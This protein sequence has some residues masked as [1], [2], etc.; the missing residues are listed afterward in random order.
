MQRALCL[1]RAGHDG[2]QCH[3]LLCSAGC[4]VPVR[5]A[6]EQLCVCM[7]VCVHVCVRV[8]VRVRV[9]GFMHSHWVEVG[10]RTHTHIQHTYTHTYNIHTRT[11]TRMHTQVQ[12]PATRI[13]HLC[14]KACLA[15]L[16]PLSHISAHTHTHTH[17][18]SDTHAQTHTRLYT[19][20]HVLTH[21][22]SSWPTCARRFWLAR[23]SHSYTL[24]HTQIGTRT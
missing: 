19:Y 7:C 21:R 12:F 16:Y 4:P 24:P 17:M 6:S 5:A 13:K 14:Q 23:P 2:V 9:K 18:Y 1:L 22:C 10:D 15:L 3:T 8:C 20:K 11:H